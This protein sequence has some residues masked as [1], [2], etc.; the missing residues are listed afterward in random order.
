VIEESEEFWYWPNVSPELAYGLYRRSQGYFYLTYG[1]WHVLNPTDIL[2]SNVTVEMINAEIDYMDVIPPTLERFP[3]G[4]MSPALDWY[5]GHFISFVE[6]WPIDSGEPTRG[7]P[8]M[9]AMAIGLAIWNMY[10]L[11]LGMQAQKLNMFGLRG[12]NPDPV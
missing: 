3:G 10:K 6:A 12:R 9:H 5:T 1:A 11:Q 8:R 2:A 7:A 4:F